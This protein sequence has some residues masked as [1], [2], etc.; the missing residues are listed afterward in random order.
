MTVAENYLQVQEVI[1]TMAQACGRSSAE[2]TLV[3]VSKGHNW[4]EMLPIYQAG[5][6][7]FGENRLQEALEKI[8]KG[9]PDIRWHMI[10]TLQKNKVRKG[11]GRFA[12]IHSVDT[13]EL[14]TKISECS[15]EK[16]VITPILLQVNTSGEFSKHG[17]PSEQWR[18]AFDRLLELPGIRLEGLMTM[19][20]FTSNETLIRNCFANLRN[21]KEELKNRAGIKAP[22]SHLSMGMSNDYRYAILE[23][24]TLLRVGSAIFNCTQSPKLYN[25][26]LERR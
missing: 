9:S 7:N 13:P 5:C 10:G 21:F 18:Q 25:L 23:G 2:I 14:A 15:I 6:R 3:V 8:P 12:L 24:A 20:A 4:E 17:L 19:A 11:I 22:M 1:H 16:G 26:K